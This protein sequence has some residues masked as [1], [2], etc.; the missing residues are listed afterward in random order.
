MTNSCIDD[1]YYIQTLKL[2][3][4]HVAAV[5][6]VDA[7]DIFCI[8][9]LPAAKA[10]ELENKGFSIAD[11]DLFDED[12][13]KSGLKT[14]YC[15][16]PS[17]TIEQRQAVLKL[18]FERLETHWDVALES[19]QDLQELQKHSKQADSIDPIPESERLQAAFCS[20]DG[21]SSCNLKELAAASWQFVRPAELFHVR[22]CVGDLEHCQQYLW[23]IQRLMGPNCILPDVIDKVVKVEA[24]LPGFRQREEELL[25]G[26][27]AFV[28]CTPYAGAEHN[29]EEALQDLDTIFEAQIGAA[30]QGI[31][32]GSF[33]KEMAPSIWPDVDAFAAENERLGIER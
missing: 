22:E 26:L 10:R 31:L 3:E 23:Q 17:L 13:S 5:D 9:G 30:G 6:G 16:L 2:A 27:R 33:R 25:D 11:V 8:E 14:A 1:N 29:I 21:L 15:H 28:E 19:V 18:Y 4:A 20:R 12:D 7:A 32:S 24:A